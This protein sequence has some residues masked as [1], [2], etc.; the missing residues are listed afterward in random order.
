MDDKLYEQRRNL[1]IKREKFEAR[2]IKYMETLIR[3]MSLWPK[4]L[5]NGVSIDFHI[6]EYESHYSYWAKTLFKDIKNAGPSVIERIDKS[7]D[8]FHRQLD[9][10]EDALNELISTNH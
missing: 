4:S 8:S 1:F 6:F 7:L 9:K 5:P 2:L 3:Y 10:Y